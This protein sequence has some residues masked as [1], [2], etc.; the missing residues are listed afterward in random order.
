MILKLNTKR[1]PAVLLVLASLWVA[2]FT[3][4][5]VFFIFCPTP[6]IQQLT[7]ALKG[8]Q[9]PP[10]GLEHL[11]RQFLDTVGHLKRAIPVAA[12]YFGSIDYKPGALRISRKA[13]ISY[14]AWLECRSHPT[15]LIITRTKT[16]NSAAHI[17]VAEGRPL[18]VVRLYAAPVIAFGLSLVLYYKRHAIFGQE[19]EPRAT[20]LDRAV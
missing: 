19:R 1:T 20:E 13:E 10:E 5:L 8:Q 6:D 3:L 11:Q 16:S 17:H 14:L 15:L 18:N 2:L 7:S 9:A 12:F 4:P